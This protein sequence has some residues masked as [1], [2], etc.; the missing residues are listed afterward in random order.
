MAGVDG[1][2]SMGGGETKWVGGE[3]TTPAAFYEA[4]TDTTVGFIFFDRDKAEAVMVGA[5]G[6]EEHGG[7]DDGRGVGGMVAV[8]GRLGSY[9]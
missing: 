8:G 9:R 7:S 6:G 5:T 4:A 1:S 3:G 2:S